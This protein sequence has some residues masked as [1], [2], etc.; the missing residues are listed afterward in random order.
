MRDEAMRGEGGGRKGEGHRWWGEE[1]RA[2]KQ[3]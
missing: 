1:E 3:R 2:R